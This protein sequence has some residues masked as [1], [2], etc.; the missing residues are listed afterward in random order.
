MGCVDLESM[1][2]IGIV[3]DNIS[4]LLPVFL[5]WIVDFFLMKES[6]NSDGKNF[7]NDLNGLAVKVLYCSKAGILVN[8]FILLVTPG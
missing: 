7:E 5:I 6:K 2:A 1:V 8:T 3:E 4:G